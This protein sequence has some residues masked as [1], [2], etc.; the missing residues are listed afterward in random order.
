ME[1]VLL[2]AAPE[3]ERFLVL[4]RFVSG[5]VD[6][7]SI[8]KEKQQ[9][10]AAVSKFEATVDGNRKE[11]ADIVAGFRA[12]PSGRE[13]KTYSRASVRY[14]LARRVTFLASL[15]PYLLVAPFIYSPL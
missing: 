12:G 6:C 8:F 9:Q 4:C 3:I 2:F 10:T 11:V 1:L 15:P 5:L 7:I 14:C 13:L